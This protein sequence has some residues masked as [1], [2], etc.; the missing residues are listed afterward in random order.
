MADTS[1]EYECY[2]Q[3]LFFLKYSKIL[4]I[5]LACDKTGIELLNIP[6]YQTV[7]ILA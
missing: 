3:K 5:Q 6:N 7:P 1:L 2:F 4:L